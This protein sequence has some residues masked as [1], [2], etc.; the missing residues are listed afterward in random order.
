MDI[1]ALDCEL[2]HTTSGLELARLTVLDASGTVVM[3][4]FTRPIGAVVDLVTRFSGVQE[5][6]LDKAVLDIDGA[7]RAL[8]AMMGVNTILVGHGLENDLKALRLVHDRLIDTAVVRSP[9]IPMRRPS[10]H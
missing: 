3:D 7:R 1:L 5:G 4:E 2:I 9:E 10:A 6:D 8:G